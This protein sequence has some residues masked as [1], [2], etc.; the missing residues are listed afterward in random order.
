[1]AAEPEEIEL[2]EDEDA[3]MEV[4]FDLLTNKVRLAYTIIAPLVLT[5]VPPMH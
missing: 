3:R 4:D 1:M 2:P 5:C